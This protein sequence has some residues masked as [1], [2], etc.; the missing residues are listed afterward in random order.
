MLSGSKVFISGVDEAVNVL[1]VG[2]TE[3]AKTGKLKPCLFVVPTDAAGLEAR[4]IQD[5][6]IIEDS[7]AVRVVRLNEP[8]PADYLVTDRLPNSVVVRARGPRSVLLLLA[9]NPPV[10][11]AAPV[12]PAIKQ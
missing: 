11:Q 6:P 12:V 4:P 7:I 8:A 1:V 2:R 3:D 10:T 9:A 5:D